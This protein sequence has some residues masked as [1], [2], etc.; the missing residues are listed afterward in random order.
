M[1]VFPDVRS[2]R[3]A[4]RVRTP[5]A[6]RGIDQGPSAAVFDAAE[7]IAEFTFRAFVAPEPAATI[8][9]DERGAPDG[10][11]NIRTRPARCERR[12][13]TGGGRRSP[14]KD[15]LMAIFF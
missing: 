15:G 2:T 6:F 13:R 8:Q 12:S 9:L 14:I 5:F 3:C 7:R 11:E 10:A 4:S 1:P